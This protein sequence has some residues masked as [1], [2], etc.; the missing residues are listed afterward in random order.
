MTAKAQHTMTSSRDI[1]NSATGMIAESTLD[2]LIA[3]VKETVTGADEVITGIED[4]VEALNACELNA[5]EYT[6]FSKIKRSWHVGKPVKV[7]GHIRRIDDV[8]PDFIGDSLVDHISMEL[9]DT[10]GN[11]IRT[12]TIYDDQIISRVIDL[13]LQYEAFDFYGCTVPQPVY[14]PSGKFKRIRYA[15]L[16]SA[17][18]P[19]DDPIMMVRASNAEIKKAA[20]LVK[21][22]S[23]KPNA[24]FDY[25]RE[26]LVQIIGI[27]GLEDAPTLDLCLKAMIV[28][29]LSDG[30]DVG[31]S[32]SHRLHTLVIGSPAVG[33]KLLTEVA[34]ILNP[35][36][37]EAHPGKITIPGIAG[38]AFYKEGSWLSEPGLIP[39]AHR[40][41]F[42]IQDFHHVAKKKEVMGIFSMVMEDGVV[43]D[44]T[45]AKKKHHALTAIHLDLNKSSDIY[46]AGG[47]PELPSGAARLADI[48]LSMNVLTRFDFIAEIP[49]DSERQMQIALQMH[50]GTHRTARFPVAKSTTDAERELRV[51]VAY[52]RTTFAEVEIPESLVEG[53]IRSKQQ[54]LLEINR[55]RINRLQLL[56]DY[57][58]RLAN[59]IHKYVY[60]IARGNGRAVAIADDVD[61]A[62]RFIHS[63][64][65]FLATIEPFETPQSWT[66][67]AGANKVLSRRE[68][69]A[70]AFAGNEV[71]V[72]EVRTAVITEYGLKV[73]ASTIRRDLQEIAQKTKHGVFHV[74]GS[75]NG[76]LKR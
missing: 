4:S 43:I 13:Y 28:Q 21:T 7:R 67:P 46:L 35:V 18:N 1:I 59:S 76:K 44:S 54:E 31:R 14:S 42:A 5:V 64:M 48:G 9:E 27:K 22:L 12:A 74:P 63:K 75:D 8:E 6:L 51:L 60:A 69:I 36:F 32:F 19:S 72:E 34:R 58:T 49:R 41:V 15:F 23:K 57:Q 33:K 52:L 61:E 26:Q 29:A 71:T 39:L 65:E 10:E 2:L 45:A 30:Y 66:A 24:I 17:I 56:G 62:F 16:I 70:Q 53:H 40:G 47:K 50:S 3:E 11:T 38:R 68:Y 73:S 20:E 37:T 25:I 55:N